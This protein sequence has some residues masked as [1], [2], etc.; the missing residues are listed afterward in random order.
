MSDRWS[1][2][3]PKKHRTFTSNHD[4]V[5]EFA[6][7]L[8]LTPLLDVMS[9]ILFFLLAGFGAAIVSFLAASVPVQADSNAE[10]EPPR[11]DKV[12]LMVQLTGA[13]YQV[14]ISGDS[15]SSDDV[16][17]FK[18]E[19]AKNDNAALRELAYKVKEKYPSSDT[20]M[21]VPNDG[22]VY[23]EIVGAM[24][25]T[26]ET[27]HEGKRIRLFPKAVVADIV[28]GEAETGGN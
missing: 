18:R 20:A 6:V 14:S 7:D 24:E 15:L 2:F 1:M 4:G 8:N 11:T 10:A 28:R 16:A 13:A 9:N 5:D 19:V 12:T 21:F 3:G 25:A 23:D 27:H 17:E 26:K 22:S